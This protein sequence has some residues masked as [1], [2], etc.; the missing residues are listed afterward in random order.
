MFDNNLLSQVYNNIFEICLK[1]IFVPRSLTPAAVTWAMRPDS[2]FITICVQDCKDVTLDI[3]P[4][5]V[6]FKGTGGPD[7]KTYENTLELYEEIDAEVSLWNCFVC[8][9][10]I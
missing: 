6:Y 1:T 9:K 5:K 10:L 2:V 3:S 8:V 4:S 7:N